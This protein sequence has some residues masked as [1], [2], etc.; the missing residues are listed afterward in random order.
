MIMLR[1]YSVVIATFL[2]A[3]TISAS[4][5]SADFV[6][7]SLNTLHLGWGSATNTT[8]KCTE[9]ANL[10]GSVD[11]LLLQEVM[12]L[13]VPCTNLGTGLGTDCSL[14]MLGKTSYKE[15]YCF[16]YKKS[17]MTFAN[18][19]YNAPT[20]S[21]SRPPY[22]ILMA[23]KVGTT[24]KYVWFA[25]IHSI[26]GKTVGPRQAEASAAGIFFQ[27][28]Q[29]ITCSPIAIPTNGFPVIIGGDW[30]LS[31]TSSNG[32]YTTGFSWADPTGNPATVPAAC[33]A[34]AATSL[35][36]AGAPSSPY[37]HIIITGI[38][39]T[40]ANT[41]SIYPTTSAARTTWRKTVSDHMAVYWEVDFK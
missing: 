41:C 17:K 32:S 4:V 3:M 29:N 37:D 27:T 7:G 6:V 35:T 5:R 26:F 24:N 12:Q 30:N 34:N 36:P 9:I 15:A 39:L 21:F 1:K 2:L 8:N 20:A 23:V 14:T 38:S 10:M 11:I 33:P 19:Y 18:C 16:V 13:A 22:A 28:L 25:N 31:V 40:G